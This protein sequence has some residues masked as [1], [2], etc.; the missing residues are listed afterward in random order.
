MAA[1]LSSGAGVAAGGE[2]SGDFT[3]PGDNEKAKKKEEM[4]AARLSSSL[5]LSAWKI[6]GM[7]EE[8]MW[9]Q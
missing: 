6:V 8:N 3:W 9:R 2:T 5:A 1:R 4:V 7:R